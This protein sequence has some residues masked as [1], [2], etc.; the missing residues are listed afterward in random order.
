[1]SACLQAADGKGLLHAD[2]TGLCAVIEYLETHEAV[3][4]AE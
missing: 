3:L 4:G 1:M 2:P